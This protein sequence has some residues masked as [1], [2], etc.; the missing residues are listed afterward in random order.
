M[1]NKNAHFKLQ[2]MLRRIFLILII[3]VG[4]MKAEVNAQTPKWEQ[5]ILVD[6]FIFTKAPYPSCHAATI[7][8]TPDGLV[9]AW[10][11]GTKE[12]NPDVGIWVSRFE[13]GRWTPSVEVANG[14]QNDTLRYPTWNPVL[15][16]IPNGE[17]MLFY[18]V[19]PSPSTWWGMLM[20]SADHGK[21][22]GKQQA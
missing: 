8:E 21:T 18:K 22:W 1:N 5:G 15:F 2:N 20:K 14:V 3:I 7:A 11:G 6:E 17:L 4:L 16:Q 9:T 10:F 12:R 13:A 19:G